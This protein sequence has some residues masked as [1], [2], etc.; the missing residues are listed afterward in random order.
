MFTDDDMSEFLRSIPVRPPRKPKARKPAVTS[1]RDLKGL[2]YGARR[3]WFVRKY[4][5]SYADG[6]Y[7]DSPFP[8]I[9]TSNGL[10]MAIINFL[11]WSGHNA[12]RTGTQGRMIKV[13]GQYKR[14]S[15]ANRKGTSD[16]SAT[17]KGR[18][19]KLEIKIGKDKP[20]TEQLQEQERERSAGGVY[21]FIHSFDEFFE[22][23]F[24]F[25]NTL[26]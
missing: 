22:W 11:N 24:L 21:E 17:I 20:S 23:Y 14:I 10:T 7:Y 15:S 25:L 9:Q 26:L 5:A 1:T 4:K 18:A 16:I 6:G 2:Y 8:K 13:N 19:I 3:E 12:D